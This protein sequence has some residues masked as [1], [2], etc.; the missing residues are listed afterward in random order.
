MAINT[1]CTMTA[2]LQV[3]IVI[4]AIAIFVI[5]F[6]GKMKNEVEDKMEQANRPSPYEDG[7]E[8]E[9]ETDSFLTFDYEPPTQ[10]QKPPLRKSQKKA[11]PKAAP[12]LEEPE[13]DTPPEFDIH[14]PEEVRRAI[15]WSE[16]LN[17]KYT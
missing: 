8:F 9:G 11:P 16:I 5:R 7:T 2:S 3:I 12:I 10:A 13:Q 17:R 14:S 1:Q 15:I 6:L 4:A